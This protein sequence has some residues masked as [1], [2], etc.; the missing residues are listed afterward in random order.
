MKIQYLL[1]FMLLSCTNKSRELETKQSLSL[2]F[3]GNI[4]AEI[5]PCGCRQF[6]LGGIDN[7]Y[8]ALE[9][10]RKNSSILFIDTGDSFYQAGFVPDSEKNSSLEKAK[11]VHE[12]LNLLGLNLKLI[13]E[14]DT[15]AGI[16]SLKSL[17][18]DAKYEIIISNLKE[19][20]DI[21]HIKF[22]YYKFHE[23]RLFFI[24]VVNPESMQEHIR[25]LFNSP[26]T[27]INSVIKKLKSENSFNPR[28][29]NHHLILLSHSGQQLEKEI[30]E[31]IQG[32]DWILGSHSMNFTQ[33]P[34]QIKQTK[35]AQMLSR[36]HY[37]GKISFRKGEA[38][39]K[40]STVEINQELSKKPI[41]N[42]LIKFIQTKKEL[43]D[44][45]QVTEQ[46]QNNHQFYQTEQIPTSSSCIDCHDTQGTFWQSTP[47]SL[48]YIT[49][50]NST[51]NH[52]LDCLK[53]HSL[54]GGNPKGYIDSQKIVIT[55]NPEDYWKDVF[56]T[57]KPSKKIR[58]LPSKEILEHSKNWYDLDLKHNVSHNY[59]NVQC[60]NCH[61]QSVEHMNLP[62]KYKS[63]GPEALKKACLNCHTSDQSTH[64]YKEGQLNQDVFNE[65]Y[66]KVS[67]PKVITE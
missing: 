42:P 3:T 29:P 20:V 16:D 43:I 11:A 46:S 64:W 41:S 60:L 27:S 36:N 37:L 56:S 39:S 10:E 67:C 6:P 44:K 50:K 54:G 66:K 26:I 57:I 23:H 47:H 34:N 18:R 38:H 40:Y 24:G 59:T 49:L 12:G 28:D 53:C 45:I 9:E 62:S 61:Q 51:K 31:K 13:G 48:A 1:L 25:K 21:P 5:E 8:G 15:A 33:K 32:I 14:Q 58:D 17:I 65:M 22:K 30:A 2:I 63:T 19:S 4:N 52:D 35:L 55:E 7:V